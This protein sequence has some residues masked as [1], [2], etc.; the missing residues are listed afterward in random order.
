MVLAAP[1]TVKIF[2]LCSP[3]CQAAGHVPR[4]TAALSRDNNPANQ[5][6]S[7]SSK[8]MRIAPYGLDFDCFE[9]LA[10]SSR[11]LVPAT[12][13]S[14]ADV[15][16]AC[17]AADFHSAADQRL[18]GTHHDSARRAA[19]AITHVAD[20]PGNLTALISLGIP[21]LVRFAVLRKS[22]SNSSIPYI[23]SPDMPG[24]G[25]SVTGMRHFRNRWQN[26]TLGRQRSILCICS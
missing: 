4:R 3:E 16:P 26:S 9:P 22:A 12:R 13:P 20:G 15:Y 24:V 1:R 8:Y 6:V 17:F 7:D 25:C 19:G 2:S 23:G 21:K 10:A 18:I 11:R 5:F 14:R